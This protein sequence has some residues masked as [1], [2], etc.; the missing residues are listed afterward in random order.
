LPDRIDERGLIIG[1]KPRQTRRFR[2]GVCRRAR[3]LFRRRVDFHDD[4][5]Q[6]CQSHQE[7]QFDP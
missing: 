5:R 6:E 4:Q 3:T 1:E 2:P 7:H